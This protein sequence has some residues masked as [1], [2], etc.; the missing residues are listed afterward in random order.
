M[1]STLTVFHVALVALWAL[2]G[3]FGTQISLPGSVLSLLGSLVII[4]LL[5]TEHRRSVRPSV[6]LVSYLALS[7]LLD[8]AQA[9]TL[10]LRSPDNGAIQALFTA[11]LAT[12]LALLCLEELQKVPL[13]NEDKS[14]TLA[15][16]ETSGPINRSVF[17]WLNEL[18]FK[19][20]K[21]LLQVEDLGS[22]DNR[23]DS[24]ELFL[25]LH[26]AWQVTKKGGKHSL[27]AA[28]FSAFKVAFLAPVIPRLCL[29]GFS[30]AQ[31]FLI[32]RVVSFVGESE[33][34]NPQRNASGIAGGLI[35]ATFLV[36]LGL[37][38]SFVTPFTKRCQG[39]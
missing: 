8:L 10:F 1:A 6:L 22:I 36:Y 3:T 25:K 9:R 18:F 30:F 28:T 35:G 26:S 19:G 7:I 38:V 17:W 33:S 27:I 5:L 20:F 31:P 16:E 4:I 39:N 15:L 34:N 37:A 11:S 32:N 2:P 12:K 24:A 14:R 21:G 13:V 29:A 23:F